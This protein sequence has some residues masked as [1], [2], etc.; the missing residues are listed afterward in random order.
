[1]SFPC[2]VPDE[3]LTAVSTDGPPPILPNPIVLGAV[4]AS[5]LGPAALLPAV[6][7]WAAKT[8]SK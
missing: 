7:W 2:D 1:M 3:Q 5:V 6:G 4:V 8:F